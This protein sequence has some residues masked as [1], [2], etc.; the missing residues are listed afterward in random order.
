[1]IRFSKFLPVRLNQFS[2]YHELSEPVVSN[3][4]DFYM[5]CLFKLLLASLNGSIVSWVK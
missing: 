4:F 5:N 2:E 3:V 1:M